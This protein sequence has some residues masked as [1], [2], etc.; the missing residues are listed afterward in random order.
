MA[1]AYGFLDEGNEIHVE[2]AMECIVDALAEHHKNGGRVE[3]G[4]R[5]HPDH[6]IS[7]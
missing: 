5:A 4:K 2:K 1:L 6:A 7:K 3:K